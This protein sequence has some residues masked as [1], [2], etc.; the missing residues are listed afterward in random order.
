MI[1]VLH[2]DSSRQWG[3]GQNQVRLLMRELDKQSIHQL[4]ICPLHSPLAARLAS[5]QLPVWPVAWRMH[6][7]P[8]AL[9]A[10]AASMAGYDVVHC[11]DAHAL[12]LALLPAAIR[13]R[14]VVASRRVRFKTNAFTWNRADRVI[15]ISG[16][17]RRVLLDSGIAPERIRV[18]HSGVDVTEV[19][20]VAP[21]APSLRAQ[22]SI[23][24]DAFVVGNAG[25]FFEA[26]G[27]VLIPEAAGLLR[28]VHWLIAGEGPQRA[29]IV[30]GIDRNRVADR[31]HLLG[32]L[33]DARSML[34]EIDAFASTSID[35]ALGNVVL[36]AMAAHVPV[37]AANAGGPAEV[38]EPVNAVARVLFEPRN[39]QDL[40]GVVARLRDP[41]VR[42]AV[43]AAQDLRIRDFEIARTA[44]ATLQVYREL[45]DRG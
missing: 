44:E 36:E 38:L 41:A 9:A 43:V 37:I 39:A 42:A 34:S 1:S 12:Q 17:V 29:A 5:E 13:R 33:P 32:W 25:S 4:C 28:D 20:A 3:G 24:A 6:L 30:A 22:L 23:P 10:I 15:A 27:Q 19:R 40:A 31:V 21:A 2:V 11:H 35:D 16:T 45:C 26:K 14:K 8:R 18:I 7:D